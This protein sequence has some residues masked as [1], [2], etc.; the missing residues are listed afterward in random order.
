MNVRQET[1]LG[2]LGCLLLAGCAAPSGRI[3]PVESRSVNQ[4]VP[5]VPT[6]APASAPSD[7]SV[8]VTAMPAP[9]PASGTPRPL[10]PVTPSAAPPAT[11]TPQAASSPAPASPPPS[12]QQLA[13]VTPVTKTDAVDGILRDVRR[14]WAAGQHEQAAAGLERA[15][16]I[17]PSNPYLWQHLAA[18]RL[19]QGKS[20]QAEQFA[21]KS[22]SVAGDS[23]PLR[24]RNWRIIA[25]AR[26][27][28]G[29]AAGAREAEARAS[30]YGTG[31]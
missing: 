27:L 5:V 7:A 19:D 1:L 25:E 22:N 9:E 14:N 2:L 31:R 24:L 17:E 13:L 26:R 4:P 20:Q 29:D 21:A 3:A 18:V 6:P 12:P 23:A 30:T 10:Y 11:P 16:R 15:L 28:G 8:T